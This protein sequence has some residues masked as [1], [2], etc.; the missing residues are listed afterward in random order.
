MSFVPSRKVW[1]QLLGMYIYQQNVCKNNL[2][3]GRNIVYFCVKAG[4]IDEIKAFYPQAKS[5]ERLRFFSWG[6]V[7]VIIKKSIRGL[8]RDDIICPKSNQ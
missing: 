2:L 4:G 8:E 3:G 7:I 6:C 1:W 5:C